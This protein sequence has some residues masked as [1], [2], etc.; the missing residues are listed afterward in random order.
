VVDFD[1]PQKPLLPQEMHGFT[2]RHTEFRIIGLCAACTAAAGPG[3]QSGGE[4]PCPAPKR[5]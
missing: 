1:L 4:G 2:T 5:A 3:V